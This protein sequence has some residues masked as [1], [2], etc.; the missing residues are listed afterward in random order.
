MSQR[1]YVL[2][3][4]ETKI[5]LV[6]EESRQRV[7]IVKPTERIFFLERGS[8]SKKLILLCFDEAYSRRTALVRIPHTTISDVYLQNSIIPLVYPLKINLA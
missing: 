8:V 6:S 2:F 4:D 7:W 1:Q 3:S 5:G